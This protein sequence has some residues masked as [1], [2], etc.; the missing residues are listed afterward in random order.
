PANGTRVSVFGG[1]PENELIAFSEAKLPTGTWKHVAVV[2]TAGTNTIYIDGFPA[3]HV[4]NAPN[5]PPREMEPM[6]SSSWL[7][8][9]RFPD[10]AGLNGTLDEFRIYKRA[11]APSEIADLAWP[12]RDYA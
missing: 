1:S 3:I 4:E 5:V 2:G 6:S 10:D 8:K 12:K 9:S 7:G 11:L